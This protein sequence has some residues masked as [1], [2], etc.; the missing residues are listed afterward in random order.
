MTASRHIIVNLYQE[1]ADS[2]GWRMASQTYGS[3]KAMETGTQR[4]SKNWSS[5][6]Q[7]IRAETKHMGN[8]G[9]STSGSTIYGMLICDDNQG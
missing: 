9:N 6:A 1:S 5:W 3:R 7:P 4:A 8:F 2:P